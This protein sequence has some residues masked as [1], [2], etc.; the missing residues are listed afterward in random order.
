MA[1]W[2]RRDKA[3]GR[4]D[5]ITPEGL[6]VAKAG[7]VFDDLAALGAY[8]TAH[9]IRIVDP[10][11][12]LSNYTDT[13][14][15]A[16]VWRTQPSVRKVVDYIAR[17]LATIPWHVYERVSDTDRRRVTDHPLARLLAAPGPSLTA[18]RLW[19]QV[20]VD[21]LIYDRWCV[22]VLPNADTASG[23]ELRRKPARRFHI[24]AD[25]D[26]QPEALYLVSSSGPA[27]TVPLA[28]YLFDHGYATSG[29]DG[30]SPMDTLRQILA[31]QSESVA[32]RRQV[33]KNGAQ[34]SAVIERPADAPEWSK[35]AKARF[36]ES[37][38]RFVGKGGAAGGTPIL[39]DGMRLVPVT[40]FSPRDTLD[41]EGRRLTDAEVASSYHIPPE[42]VG[43]RDGTYSSI[44]AFRQMLYTH[45]VGPDITMLQDV[46]NAM[47]VPIVAGAGSNLYVEAYVE[48]KLRGSFMEQAAVLQSAVGAPYMLRSE[49]RSKLNLPQV[50]GTDQLVTPLNVLIGGL[51]SPRDTAPKALPGP[52]RP[53]RPVRAKAA[54]PE[55]LG[56]F[57]AE[58]DA[59]TESLSGW[60]A[61]Q[62]EQLLDQAGAKADGPPDFYSLWA[63]SSPERQAQLA[64]L[65]QAHGLRLAQVGAWAVLDDYNPDADGWD[66][67]VMEAW[68]AAAA[69]SHAEQY[70]QAGYTAALAAVG[71]PDGWQAG[72]RKTMAS[73]VTAATLRAVTAATEARSFGGHDAAGASGLTYKVWNT[74][75]SPRSTHARLDGDRVP[76]DD[77]FGNGLRWPGDAAGSVAE[78]AGCNCRLTYEREE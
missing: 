1:F 45:S 46:L 25:D 7:E 70:E 4:G 43:A 64:A 12:P 9:G 23:W 54:R 63:A 6:P 36:T 53:P 38:N 18:S 72:L 10:G 40:A 21:W 19:H 16:D 26:D 66:P 67:A 58:R 55:E 32:Y 42:L 68:L 51:A 31:E 30:T 71:D 2:R 50:E 39:E 15:A 33:W 75:S 29:A 41:I 14:A 62:A 27:R 60:A 48:A 5:V 13:A 59:L 49:A 76:L 69:A 52:G 65:I 24:L 28:G 56:T 61:R 73:W 3:I 20:I 77:V 78:T 74:G 8:A 37:F 17:A 57:E 11:V 22:Q 34:V 47:L 35:T 44:D